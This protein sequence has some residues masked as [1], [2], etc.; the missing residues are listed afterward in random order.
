MLEFMGFLANSNLCSTA[1][2]IPMSNWC[3]HDHLLHFKNFPMISSSLNASS[4]WSYHLPWR[5]TKLATA[6]DL[7]E[8]WD[9]STT[10]HSQFFHSHALPDNAVMFWNTALSL[11]LT[12]PFIFLFSL[13]LAIVLS[14][15]CCCCLESVWQ[16]KRQECVH[17]CGCRFQSLLHFSVFETTCRIWEPLTICT[18]FKICPCR[19]CVKHI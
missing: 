13:A 14:L 3:T 6:S 9:K 10:K 1:D 18:V 7:C 2:R 17:V 16:S 8:V 4:A 5:F 19:C 12:L 15:L 11:S